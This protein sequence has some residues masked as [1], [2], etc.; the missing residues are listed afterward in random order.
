[1]PHVSTVPTTTGCRSLSFE[2]Q[3][4]GEWEGAE[5]A[6]DRLT[7]ITYN[8]PDGKSHTKVAEY[9]YNAEGRLSPSGT[10]ESRRRSKRPTSTR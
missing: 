2:Y 10:P 4:P 1:M 8:G 9:E 5:S 3:H 7:S 6:G